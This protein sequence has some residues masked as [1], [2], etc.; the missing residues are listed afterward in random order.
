MG[1]YQDTRVSAMVVDVLPPAPAN[2]RQPI[3]RVW[4]P[5]LQRLP[6]S[7]VLCVYSYRQKGG[8]PHQR[9]TRRSATTP[10]SLISSSAGDNHIITSSSLN[11]PILY[12]KC[13]LA[14]LKHRYLLTP[15]TAV[16]GHNGFTRHLAGQNLIPV[17]PSK[18]KLAQ[19]IYLSLL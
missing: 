16:I 3:G 17:C 5:P 19:M 4:N 13:S 12:L 15:W 10:F 7:S 18:G 1:K 8:Q 14:V 9:Q 11:S 2:G 6:L